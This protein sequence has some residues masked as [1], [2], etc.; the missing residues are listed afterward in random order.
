[1]AMRLILFF[2]LILLFIPSQILAEE[3][4]ADYPLYRLTVSFDIAKSKI[5]GTAKFQADAGQEIRLRIG[6]LTV[7]AI[8]V[9][10]ASA[11][12]SLKDGV[13][14]FK[15]PL[16]GSAEISYAG[17]FKGGESIENHNY[18]VSS[19]RIERQGISLTGLWYPHP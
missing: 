4:D 15:S 13:I 14:S 11:A 16:P 17:I 9:N 5:T 2:F 12:F 6:N 1:M 19:D 7:T 10:G 18:S 8:A 3:K